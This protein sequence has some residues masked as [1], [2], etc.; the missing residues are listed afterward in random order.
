MLSPRWR[1]VSGDLWDNKGRTLLVVASIAIGIIAFGGLFTTRSVVNSNLDR[2]FNLSNPLDMTIDLSPFEDELVHWAERQ[3]YIVDA[4]GVVT[5]QAEMTIG[6]DKYDI[7]MYAFEDYDNITINQLDPERGVY[8]PG[9]AEFLVERS[10]LDT[11]GLSIGQTGTAIIND[12]L[13]YDLQLAGTL[14][15]VNVQPAFVTDVIPVYVTPRTLQLLGLSTDFNTLYLTVNRTLLQTT[16]DSLE[17][18]ADDLRDNLEDR[19]LTVR[20]VN[21]EEESAHWAADNVNG[22][23]T[24]LSLVGFFALMLSGF[25]VVNTIAGFLAQQRKTIGIMKIIGAARPEIITL[26]MVMVAAFGVMA[27]ALALPGSVMVARA[28]SFQLG[29][30]LINFDILA[31]RIPIY[32]LL[33]EFGVAIMAP[34]L[35]ALSPILGGTRISAAAAI[36]DYNA[37]SRTNPIDVALAKLGGLPRP[38]LLAIRNTFRR[39]M[40]LLFTMMTLILAGAFFMAIINVRE[41]VQ[42]DIV[43]LIRMS[44]YD[45]QLVFS[46]PYDVD[47]V[48]RRAEDIPGVVAVEGWIIPS[49]SRVRPDGTQSESIQLNAVPYNSEFIAPDMVSGRWL[50]PLT[51]D[52]R[53]DLVI[54][55]ELLTQEPDLEVGSTMTLNYNGD[56]QDWTIVGI[57]DTI[58]SPLVA[59]NPIYAHDESVARFTDQMGLASMVMIRTDAP[60]RELQQSVLDEVEA[61]LDTLGFNIAATDINAE[62]LANIL[63]N[64]DV[65]IFLLLVTAVMIAIVG[66]LGLAGTMSLSV[67][68]RTREIGVMRSVGADN[69]TLRFMFIIEGVLIGLMS[70]VFAIFLSFPFT[71]GF[72]Y[73][74]GIVIRDKPFSYNLT[75]LG[76]VLWLIIVIIV[77]AVASLLPAQRASSISIRE[78][79]AYE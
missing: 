48:R 6:G 59:G 8:P 31:F 19:G 51:S 42:T 39:K 25:L 26:Y 27:F 53:Y 36:S 5:H 66:G 30:Q 35:S 28:L 63:S 54:S 2:Q 74:L 4:Q 43:D 71:Y 58:D 3:T 72:G 46:Q 12:E 70:M 73:I 15:D 10:Y 32:I 16:G 64:F 45:V 41:S 56:E 76:P 75:L 38:V 57:V 23:S 40:R 1:K 60:T 55:D 52:T 47:G 77:S 69:G 49:V 7:V 22:I 34:I 61:S 62:L 20:G 44:S 13:E 37:T 11:F 67:L 50:T 21:V 14:H 65:I 78:A 68:E 17:T 18:V 33:L 24:I 9:R 79:L 29:P